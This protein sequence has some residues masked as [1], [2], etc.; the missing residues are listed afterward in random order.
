MFLVRGSPAPPGPEAARLRALARRFLG[1]VE[2]RR[3]H[4]RVHRPRAHRR[5]P[6]AGERYLRARHRALRAPGRPAAVHRHAQYVLFRQHPPAVP[7]PSKLLEGADRRARRRIVGAATA[8]H[9]EKR[10]PD[11]P[12]FMYELRTLMNARRGDHAAPPGRRKRRARAPRARSPQQGPASEVFLS[13]PIP[14]A[15]VDARGGK[16][17]IANQAFLEFLGCAGD[18]GGLFLGETP[19]VDVYPAAARRS[20][21]G[22]RRPHHGQA[23]AA[24]AR[25]ATAPPLT[26]RSS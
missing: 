19:L 9:P 24:A 20:Q 6:P 21:A 23:G 1:R 3:R 15:A 26:P 8:K 4:P 14:M 25:R 16:V 11:V 5:R 7:A 18:V 2:G 22:R 13:A 12:R 17:R 10:H